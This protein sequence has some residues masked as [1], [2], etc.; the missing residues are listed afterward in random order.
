MRNGFGMWAVIVEAG[1]Y[2]ERSDRRHYAIEAR[3]GVGRQVRVCADLRDAL[4]GCFR[5]RAVVPAS[6]IATAPERPVRGNA[7]GAYRPKADIHGG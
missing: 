6:Q 4:A 5:P 7:N 1:R 2:A 3:W